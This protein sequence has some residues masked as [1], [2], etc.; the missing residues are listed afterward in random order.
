MGELPREICTEYHYRY[1][2]CMDLFSNSLSISIWTPFRNLNCIIHKHCV[3]MV[4]A[5]TMAF[6]AVMDRVCADSSLLFV[7]RGVLAYGDVLISKLQP[8][9]YKYVT[10]LIS[11]SHVH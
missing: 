5:V 8:R 11:I 9:S 4:T 7:T 2:F 1:S 10:F 3:A 6:P